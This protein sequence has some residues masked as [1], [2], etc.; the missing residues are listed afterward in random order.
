MEPDS[1]RK[2][3]DGSLLHLVVEQWGPRTREIVES[4]DAVAI[5]AIDEDGYLNLVRQAREAVRRELLELPAGGIEP[6]ETPLE[7]AK[8]ELREETGLTGGTWR[9]RVGFFTVPGFGSERM[10]LFYAEGL[11]R[12]EPS[13]VADES[14]EHVRVPV[15]EIESLL[16][17]LEDAKTLVGLLLYLQDTGR[18]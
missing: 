12:G 17:E 16:P 1:T 15:S 4:P 7:C 5:V 9:H 2:V 3:Y 18:S 10:E 8:R 6:P 11:V 13:P 14:F